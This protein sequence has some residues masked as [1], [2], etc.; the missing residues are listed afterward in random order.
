MESYPHLSQFEDYHDF[1]ATVLMSSFFFMV[2][3]KEF[4]YTV[5]QSRYVSRMFVRVP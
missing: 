3:R 1:Y 4:D 5:V 2:E